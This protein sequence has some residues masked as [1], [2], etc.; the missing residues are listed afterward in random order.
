MGAA[1]VYVLETR[2]LLVV[3]KNLAADAALIAEITRNQPVFWQNRAAAR[4]LVNGV[5]PYLSGRVSLITLDGHLLAS[6]D[7]IDGTSGS[8]VVELPD[9]R[10]IGQGETIRLQNGHL[11]KYYICL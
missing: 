10:G 4:S 2:L 1:M 3:Y 6:G 8:Q 7:Q 9:L 11:V 5:A